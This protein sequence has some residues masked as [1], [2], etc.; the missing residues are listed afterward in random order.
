M[1][2]KS[3]QR[4][5]KE[6]VVK[7][8]SYWERDRR[9]GKVG[10]SADSEA[11]GT[12]QRHWRHTALYLF[13]GSE[14]RGVHLA[15]ESP[16][17]KNA[18]REGTKNGVNEAGK[19]ARTWGTPGVADPVPRGGFVQKTLNWGR[20]RATLSAR[21]RIVFGKKDYPLLGRGSKRQES[22]TKGKAELG[23]EMAVS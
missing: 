22:T 21:R 10:G 8:E 11:T 2:G 1:P 19:T 20:S 9:T 4:S 18:M 12:R 14:A 6:G 3:P 23:S 5:K 7:R 17:G 16:L 15:G 13:K